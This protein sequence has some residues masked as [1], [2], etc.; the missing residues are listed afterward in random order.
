[1]RYFLAFLLAIPGVAQAA[2]PPCLKPAEFAGL[3]TYVLPSLIQGTSERCAK[4]LPGDA[5]L[6]Q[7]SARLVARYALGKAKAWPVAKA[8]FLKLGG[9]G[10]PDAAAMLVAMPDPTLQLMVDGSVAAITAQKLPVERCGSIDRLVSLLSP[11]PAENTAQLLALGV[12]L[13]AQSGKARFGK[14]AL[15]PA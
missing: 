4:T 1:M 10:N 3:A 2:E 7:N 13:A 12:G 5:F 15:C 8:A 9:A 14:F 11:L 6:R